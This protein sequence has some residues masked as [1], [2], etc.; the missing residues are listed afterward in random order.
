MVERK[1]GRGELW[2][3]GCKVIKGRCR[4]VNEKVG[5]GWCS[6]FSKIMEG[7]MRVKVVEEN[8]REM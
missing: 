4:E 8:G 5:E 1:N 3:S 2:K 6:G 7:E